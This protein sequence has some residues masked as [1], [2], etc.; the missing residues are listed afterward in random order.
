MSKSQIAGQGSI[1]LNIPKV[2]RTELLKAFNNIVKNFREKRWEPS[3]LNGG[4][5]CE[6]VYSM[7]E[8]YISGKYQSRPQKPSNMVDAC[9]KLEQADQNKF[10][11]S[12]R[13]QIP[14]MLIALYEI[15]NN[16][17]VGHVGE[18]VDPNHMD[19]LAVLNMCKWI[20]ADL[21]RIFHK[22][23]TSTATQMVEKLID[24]TISA[25]WRIEGKRRVLNPKLKY[26]DQMLLILC[27]SPTPVAEAD[28]I[29]WL[30]HSNPSIF[31]RDII[32][33]AHRERLIEYDENTKE[34][35]VSPIGIKYVE[36]NLALEL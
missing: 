11:R 13:I 14:R 4:K 26:E 27:D 7:L 36:D 31:R 17:G 24:R 34:L 19:A 23:D 1:L 21:I 10:C 16:R 25:V 3:E 32:R 29:D 22:T 18:D 28:L 9:R 6:V 30:E 5:F 20:L 2:H 33:K 8:G 35:Q 12:V 15:R